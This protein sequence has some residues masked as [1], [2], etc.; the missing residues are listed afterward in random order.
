ML[1]PMCNISGP[2]PKITNVVMD[3]GW[4]RLVINKYPHPES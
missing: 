1:V 2:F 4:V 3:P